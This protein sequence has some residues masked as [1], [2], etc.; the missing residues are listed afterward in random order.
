MKIK[1]L[2]LIFITFITASFYFTSCF[3]TLNDPIYPVNLVNPFTKYAT[4][5][6]SI[7]FEGA[8]PSELLAA[9]GE[10]SGRTAM[11]S[12][13]SSWV[14]VLQATTTEP[15]ITT[16]EPVIVNANSSSPVYSYPGLATTQAGIHWTVTVRLKKSVTDADASA[17][18]EDHLTL[19]LTNDNS[20]YIHD[21]IVSPVTGEGKAGSLSLTMSVPESVT[22]VT[23][24]PDNLGIVIS[25]PPTPSPATGAPKTVTITGNLASGSHAVR[26]NF[27]DANGILLYSNK[28]TINVFNNCTTSTWVNNGGTGNS[29]PISS[30]SYTVTDA[31]ISSFQANTF[32]VGPTLFSTTTGSL[33]QGYNGTLVKPLNNVTDISTII[34]ARADSTSAE[35]TILINGTIT[36]T[37]SL[38]SACNGKAAS[39]RLCGINTDKETDSVTPK[40]KLNGN[41]GEQ[42][43]Q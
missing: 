35:Y 5:Q 37:Q 23:A 27:K 32:Y 12:M 29:D 7:S 42:L 39:I 18:M 25:T 26:F 40:H 30:G 16:P 17:I 21:F 4:L 22:S 34:S 33:E 2:F 3:N 36:G 1:K 20:V 14:Y 13:D 43:L 38:T 6:G 8:V 31:M 24:D 10:N 11:P 9:R 28:Q 19:P 15:G 41:A